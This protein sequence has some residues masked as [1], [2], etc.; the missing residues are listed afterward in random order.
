MG[1]RASL[2]VCLWWREYVCE[3]MCGVSVC[4]N[5]CEGMCGVCME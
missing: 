4:V 3:G 2:G 1:A 5:V